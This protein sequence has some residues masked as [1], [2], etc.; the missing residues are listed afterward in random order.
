[1][2][3]MMHRQAPTLISV[4]G[5]NGRKQIYKTITSRATERIHLPHHPTSRTSPQ[6]SR[7]FTSLSWHPDLMQYPPNPLGKPTADRL[8]IVILTMW[9]LK[10]PEPNVTIAGSPTVRCNG[11]ALRLRGRTREGLGHQPPPIP[12]STTL[13]T[14]LPI[15]NAASVVWSP[16]NS[17]IGGRGSC[18]R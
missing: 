16:W 6:Q 12:V 1:M 5:R 8:A 15:E 18:E 4:K 10:R 13:T 14:V 9:Y 2:R 17:L 7:S 3:Q 11:P